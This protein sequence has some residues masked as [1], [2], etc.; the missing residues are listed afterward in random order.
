MYYP[1]LIQEGRKKRQ[2]KFLLKF[3]Q[4]VNDKFR[5]KPSLLSFGPYL[6]HVKYLETRLLLRIQGREKAL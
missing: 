1:Y 4:L 5:S 2:V 3:A 6:S